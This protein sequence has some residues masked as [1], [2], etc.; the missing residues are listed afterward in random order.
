[1]H[2]YQLRS[3]VKHVSLVSSVPGKG[4]RCYPDVT[5]EKV[6]RRAAL[7]VQ[8]RH[9]NISSVGEMLFQLEWPTLEERRSESRIQMLTKIIDGKVAVKCKDLKPAVD[10]SRRTSVCHNKQLQEL[11]SRT[12]Y[13]RM[14]FFPHTIR[15]WNSLP[16]NKVEAISLD[17]L[18]N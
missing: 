16:S 11:Y 13:R 17:H 3:A 18:V 2:F 12:D 9:R 10:R 14:S 4:F 1:M 15:E 6:Q 7:F 8:K 5:L